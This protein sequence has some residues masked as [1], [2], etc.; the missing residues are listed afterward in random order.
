MREGENVA[1]ER[2]SDQNQS[3]INNKSEEEG[4]KHESHEE[5]NKV[6]L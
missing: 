5:R 2:E 3:G 4:K 6:C 1:G